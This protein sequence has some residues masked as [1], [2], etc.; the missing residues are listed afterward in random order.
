[1]IG[2]AVASLLVTLWFLVE[3]LGRRFEATAIW[4]V[5]ASTPGSRSGAEDPAKIARRVFGTWWY[6]F[7]TAPLVT[8]PVIAV[9]IMILSGWTGIVLAALVVMAAAGRW[10]TATLFPYPLRIEWYLDRLRVAAARGDGA[11][12]ERIVEGIDALLKRYRRR[13]VAPLTRGEAAEAPWGDREW[14][15]RERGEPPVAERH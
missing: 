8:F 6:R 11:E 3:P 13:Q 1:M 9:A 15:F 12:A 7:C 5:K 4:V 10:Y 2:V 14:L